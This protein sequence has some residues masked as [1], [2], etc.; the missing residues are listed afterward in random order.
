VGDYPVAMKKPKPKV[1][2]KRGRPAKKFHPY[3]DAV[4]VAERLQPQFVGVRYG[5]ESSEPFEEVLAHMDD[6]G[7]LVVSQPIAP[8]ELRGFR[9]WIGTSWKD[10]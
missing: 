10:S 1:K 9:A 4:R 8:K 6:E 5:Q 7:N 3:L 2:G